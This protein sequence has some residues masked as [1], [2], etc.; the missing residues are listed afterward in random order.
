M[1]VSAAGYSQPALHARIT[2]FKTTKAAVATITI[3]CSCG[4]VSVKSTGKRS[5]NKGAK[6]SV[7]PIYLT[8]LSLNF[9]TSKIKRTCQLHRV[10]MTYTFK[11]L[12]CNSHSICNLIAIACIL[13]EN[14][15]CSHFCHLEV[16][17]SVSNMEKECIQMPTRN[18]FTGLKM[19]VKMLSSS[20]I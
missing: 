2:L 5:R 8:A 12:A 1:M 13:L 3:I 14:A 7:S 16:V 15:Y 6:K 10:A 11:C 9:L 18:F 20:G 17:S 4:V 19:P